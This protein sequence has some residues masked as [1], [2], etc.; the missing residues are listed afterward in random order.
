[1]FP[2]NL[3]SRLFLSYEHIVNYISTNVPGINLHQEH[4]V[5]F[6]LRQ[7]MDIFLPSY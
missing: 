5:N 7:F 4:L 1:M 6:T 3:Y 2:F